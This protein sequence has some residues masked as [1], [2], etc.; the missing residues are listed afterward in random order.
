MTDMV[1]RFHNIIYLQIL[2]SSLG[3]SYLYPYKEINTSNKN[4]GNEGAGYKSS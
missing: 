2:T 4:G 1:K 3:N